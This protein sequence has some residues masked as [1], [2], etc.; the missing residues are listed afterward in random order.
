MAEDFLRHTTLVTG[1]TR[2][3]GQAVRGELFGDARALVS[4]RD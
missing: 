2:S 1:S 3:I 4:G